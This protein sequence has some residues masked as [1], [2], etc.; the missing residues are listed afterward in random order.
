M[1]RL[2]TWFIGAA[3]SQFALGALI[4]AA[5]MIARAAGVYPSVSWLLP[6]H[7]EFML[8]GWAVQ[9]AMGVA[10]WV[11]PRHRSGPERGSPR[12]SLLAF[13]LINVGVVLAGCAGFDGFSRW[14]TAGH[15]AEI[16]GGFA[17]SIT[18][19]HRLP[20]SI[21]PRGRSLPVM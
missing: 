16:L 10:Y 14:A 18:I 11:L 12:L 15:V 1:P 2:S 13:G 6:F 5:L 3:M 4:G 19:W 20:R 8:I 17:F 9:L 7:I 21:V